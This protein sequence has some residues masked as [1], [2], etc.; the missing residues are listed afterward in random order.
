MFLNKFG[1]VRNWEFSPKNPDFQLLLK[2]QKIWQLK[3]CIP[4]GNRKMELNIGHRLQ[5][6]HMCPSR[7]LPLPS[8]FGHV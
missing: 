4:G 3:A 7:P 8:H 1:D 5:T 6:L 2:S